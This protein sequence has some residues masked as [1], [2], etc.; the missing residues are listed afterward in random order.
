MF[1]GCDRRDG[2]DA[3]S[4]LFG[5]P[6]FRVHAEPMRDREWFVRVETIGWVGGSCPACGMFGIGNGATATGM[7]LSAA[8]CGL[9]PTAAGGAR[10]P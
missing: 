5:M 4:V 1:H 6:R 2:H 9:S 10:H 8:S 7:T 3:V